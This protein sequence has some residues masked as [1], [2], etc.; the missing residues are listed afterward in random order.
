LAELQKCLSWCRKRRSGNRKCGEGLTPPFLPRS[1]CMASPPCILLCRGCETGFYQISDY[2][3]EE[4]NSNF[5][6]RSL[7]RVVPAGKDSKPLLSTACAPQT[8][9]NQ[10]IFYEDSRT[11][12]TQ[13]Q[14]LI[15]SGNTS[16][17][18]YFVGTHHRRRVPMLILI[19]FVLRTSKEKWSQ[20]K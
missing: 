1:F 6:P 16:M 12:R 10:T 20:Q 7:I 17:A 8:L 5:N 11:I 13:L 2:I 15:S 18:R 3:L 9:L 4:G 19:R 14:E